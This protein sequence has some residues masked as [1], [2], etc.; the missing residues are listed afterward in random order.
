MANY[1]KW[2]SS[3]TEFIK[4]NH[5]TLCDET[6]AVK[7]SQMTNENISTAM[8]RRQRRKLALKKNRG[9]PRKSAVAITSEVSSGDMVS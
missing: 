9:R 3:E 8:V 4:N 5:Q 2:T 1:K 7:L 6:L